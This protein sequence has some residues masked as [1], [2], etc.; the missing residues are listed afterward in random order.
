MSSIRQA[1]SQAVCVFML[2]AVTV[3][4]ASQTKIGSMRGTISHTQ[5]QVVPGATVVITD[6]STSVTREAQTDA[7]GLFEVPNLRR[8]TYSVAATIAGF[9]KA[10][11]TGVVLRAAS[12]VRIDLS[13]AI[14]NLEDVVTV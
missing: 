7:Q 3:P 8:G 13:L 2:L 5:P 4:A 6:E 9:S 11:R 14:G 12:V 10:Q 1:L